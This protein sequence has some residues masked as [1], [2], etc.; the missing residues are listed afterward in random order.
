MIASVAATAPGVRF[1]AVDL[2]APPIVGLRTDV[3]GFVGVAPRG[4]VGTPVAIESWRQ[5]ESVFGGLWPHGHLGYAVRAFFQNGGVRCHVVRAAAA[6]SATRLDPAVPLDGSGATSALIPAEGFVPGAVVWI[7]R[8]VPATTATVTVAGVDPVT[9]RLSWT[10]A[11]PGAIDLDRP[12]FLTVPGRTA[13]RTVA[14]PGQPADRMS[15]LVSSIAGFDV[16]AVVQIVQPATVQRVVARI[17]SVAGSTLSWETPLD[18][19]LAADGGIELT[20]G[21]TCSSAGYLSDAGADALTVSAGTEGSWGDG[22]TVAVS[23]VEGVASAGDDRVAQ[24]PGPGLVRLLDVQGFGPGDLVRLMQPGHPRPMHAIVASVDVVRRELHWRTTPPGFDRGMPFTATRI[25]LSLSATIAGQVVLALGGLSLIAEHPRHVST[26]VALAAPTLL[27]VD[28]VADGDDP[29]ALVVSPATTRLTGGGDG[30]AA[31]RPADLIGDTGAAPVGLAALARVDEVA[32]VVVPDAHLRPGAEPVLLPAPPPPDPCAPPT[33]PPCDLV[34]GVADLPEPFD[35]RAPEPAPPP[36][37]RPPAFHAEDTYAIQQ[38][39]VEGCEQLRDRV[40]VLEAPAT[41]GGPMEALAWVRGWRRR[42]D[43]A[44]AALYHPWLLLVDP[45]GSGLRAVPPGGHMAG[46]YA[47]GDLDVG[48]HKPPANVALFNVHQVQARVDEATHGLLN[49]EGINAIVPLPGRGIRPMGT[50][51]MS[52]DPQWRHVNVRRLLCMI[53]EA[54]LTGSQWAVFEPADR[55]TRELLRIGIAGLLEAVWEAGGLAGAT[56]EES[57]FV[58]C[59]DTN[60]PAAQLAEGLLLADVGVAPVVPAEFVVFRVGRTRD[61]VRL[62]GPASA[63][64]MPP[65]DFSYG[66]I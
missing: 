31:T 32:I 29:E 53:E 3:T 60:N 57:F 2:G 35:P 52:S 30:L 18:P 13:T 62:Y 44:F 16:G 37:E 14:G 23:S 43:T 25:D 54:I 19:T 48:V 55:T 58:V 24:P 40:C 7:S 64:A 51:T 50:R 61:E 36:A 33:R 10:A 59:D 39:M 47:K 22:L 17:A 1:E 42:F 63:A 9:G 6:A 15:L 41:T 34:T 28:V 5:F 11:L 26:A 56:P 45:I 27:A 66:R 38:A 4:P 49:G 8:D 12:A 65:A 20:T 21:A 46:V